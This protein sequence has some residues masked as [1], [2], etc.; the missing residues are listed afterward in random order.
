MASRPHP[1][2]L[3]TVASP[4]V[5][6]NDLL[7]RTWPLPALLTWGLAWTIYRLLQSQPIPDWLALSLATSIGALAALLQPWG[8]RRAI[9]ACGFPLSAL[10]LGLGEQAPA[11]VWLGPLVIL[12]ASY[13]ARTWRDAP[14]FPTPDNALGGLAEVV[15]LPA[16]ARILDVGCGLG[17]GLQALR[18]VYPQADL[19]GVEWSLPLSVGA[20][21]RCRRWATVE[22]ADMWRHHWGRYQM[23]YLFQ[24]PESMLQAV[25]KARH[26][27][28]P[29]SWLV[30]LEF[31]AP[32]LHPHAVL[33]PNSARPVWI[34]RLPERQQS[35]L[36]RPHMPRQ[37]GGAQIRR[38][39]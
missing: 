27:M 8:W 39:I 20:A 12:A 35:G 10:L 9:A 33:H 15:G 16:Q 3:H 31:Q 38:V 4:A 37:R 29:G 13:P 30:S 32:G 19:H 14:F 21:W 34:Y 25:A 28:A 7:R 22:R 17:H 6:L 11:W 5:S 26:E 1:T 23:V 36:L 24:R 18:R 2:P